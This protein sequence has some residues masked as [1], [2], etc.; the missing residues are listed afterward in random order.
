M[1]QTKKDI[2]KMFLKACNAQVISQTES[3]TFRSTT[4]I[5]YVLVDDRL[6]AETWLE[7]ES[8]LEPPEYF[9]EFKQLIPIEEIKS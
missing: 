2:A 9:Y 5:L 6:T 1:D 8:K 3:D 4:Y 7:Q